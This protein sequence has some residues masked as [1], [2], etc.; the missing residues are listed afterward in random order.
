MKGENPAQYSEHV[1]S[2]GQSVSKRRVLSLLQGHLPLRGLKASH[3]R[4]Q[5]S[6][7]TTGLQVYARQPA[8]ADERGACAGEGLGSRWV[9]GSSHDISR[10]RVI[11]V[12]PCVLYRKA[13]TTSPLQH[14]GWYV[15][16]CCHF[17][18]QVLVVGKSLNKCAPER[19]AQK[20]V[21]LH[22]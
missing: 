2:S 15:R 18:C 5:L 17:A 19:P 6:A 7:P 22:S 3:L 11:G 1:K 8:E 12:N 9:P 4:I 21:D 13:V 20:V 16:T 10:V 14:L